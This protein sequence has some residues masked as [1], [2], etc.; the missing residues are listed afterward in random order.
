MRLIKTP[1]GEEVVGSDNTVAP[2]EFAATSQLLDELRELIAQPR[3]DH[4]TV[5]ELCGVL[6]ML[7]FEYLNKWDE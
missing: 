3:Y 4:L 5:S 7:K 1:S 2:P 6:E